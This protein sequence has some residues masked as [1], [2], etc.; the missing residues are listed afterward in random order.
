MINPGLAA[1]W[2]NAQISSPGVTVVTDST[3]KHLQHIGQYVAM[4]AAS[5]RSG[6]R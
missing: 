3:D 1:K 6:V 5:G 2:P 4:I